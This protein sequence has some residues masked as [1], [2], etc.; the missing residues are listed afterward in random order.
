MLGSRIVGKE[1]Y[2]SCVLAL[3]VEPLSITYRVISTCIRLSL[4]LCLDGEIWR[5]EK[6]EMKIMEHLLS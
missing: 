5:E 3:E 2:Q 4:A 6:K 1:N